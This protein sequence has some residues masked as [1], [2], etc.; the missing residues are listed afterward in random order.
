MYERVYKIQ[1]AEIRPGD[2]DFKKLTHFRL[3]SGGQSG[4]SNDTKAL[5]NHPEFCNLENI[6]GKK[7][8]LL[9]TSMATL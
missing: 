1:D 6:L 5:I 8:E 9:L 4:T 2:T 3:S 7:S